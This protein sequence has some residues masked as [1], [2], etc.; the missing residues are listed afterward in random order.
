MSD[1]QTPQFLQGTEPGLYS[2]QSVGPDARSEASGVDPSSVSVL[3]TETPPSM[4][5]GSGQDP[6]SGESQMGPTLETS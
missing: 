1:T 6:D 2:V 5:A 3:G 4:A